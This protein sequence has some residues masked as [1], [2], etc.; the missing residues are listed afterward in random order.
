MSR[1]RCNCCDSPTSCPETGPCCT[2]P[3][4]CT[5]RG[6][7]QG[8]GGG[9]TGTP[10]PAMR[11]RVQ[12]SGTVEFRKQR[13]K[14]VGGLVERAKVFTVALTGGL[15][16]PDGG[17]FEMTP[18]GGGDCRPYHGELDYGVHSDEE[19]FEL[20][21]ATNLDI[22]R[23]V[24]YRARGAFDFSP[25]AALP[26]FW[27]A[28]NNL[29]RATLTIQVYTATIDLK[30]WA[31]RP[32]APG[33]STVAPAYARVYATVRADALN[34]AFPI[35]VVPLVNSPCGTQL[36]IP[37]LKDLLQYPYRYDDSGDGCPLV[38][39]LTTNS[40]RLCT[41]LGVALLVNIDLGDDF[42]GCQQCTTVGLPMPP[43]VCSACTVPYV[44]P[45]STGTLVGPGCRNH[46]WLPL[47]GRWS[48]RQVT[49]ARDVPSPPASG[50][51]RTT[52]EGSGDGAMADVFPLDCARCAYYYQGAEGFVTETRERF[53]G[54]V[55][56]LHSV[57]SLQCAGSA[58]NP[59]FWISVTQGI[60]SIALI[61]RN[62]WIVNPSGPWME[63]GDAAAM[64][65][66][67]QTWNGSAKGYRLIRVQTWP[68]E[69]GGTVSNEETY[70][71]EI[72]GFVQCQAS[73]PPP[74]PPP[75][76][77]GDSLLVMGGSG[78]TGGC[79]GCTGGGL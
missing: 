54:D 5:P 34:P 32:D 60:G 7:V 13:R 62:F 35:D 3:G 45:H 43:E 12:V 24:D 51:M 20:T 9:W 44:P 31:W 21:C 56:T 68:L 18:A 71:A 6:Y 55:E 72:T 75:P 46:F 33:L 57:R 19:V 16:S 67:V 2:A 4:R 38:G 11:C 79:G 63:L 73:P 64:G 50:I 8:A 70:E 59:E 77:G 40:C 27:G 47:R 42:E 66:T 39:E 15:P 74:P 78:G 14:V 26:G 58:T 10:P 28:G 53:G 76:G 52:V 61:E 23:P 41:S 36:T 1:H 17:A 30:I 29:L 49:E 65:F 69:G 25:V 22:V 37:V 48:F